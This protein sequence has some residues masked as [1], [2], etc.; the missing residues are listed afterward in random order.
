MKVLQLFAHL[1]R[2]QYALLFDKYKDESTVKTA[3]QI[4]LDNGIKYECTKIK[5]E[6]EKAEKLLNQVEKL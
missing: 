2:E 1:D 5:N 3:L 6:K 4:H